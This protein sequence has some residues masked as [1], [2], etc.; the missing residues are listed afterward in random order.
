MYSKKCLYA[1]VGFMLELLREQS[2]FYEHL[3]DKTLKKIKAHKPKTPKY[4]EK[5]VDSTS[6]RD[7][8]LYIPAV[9]V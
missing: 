2:V 4:I 5:S 1:K 7:W 8:N 6:N 3:N 9:F